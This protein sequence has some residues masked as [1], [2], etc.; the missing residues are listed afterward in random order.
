M[1]SGNFE[2]GSCWSWLSGETARLWNRASTASHSFF[3]P[4]SVAAVAWAMNRSP[5]RA[6]PAP[7]ESF[8]ATS[9]FFLLPG[10][11]ARE[12][13]PK[14]RRCRST[15]QSSSTRPSSE[16]TRGSCEAAA[17]RTVGDD[18][19]ALRVGRRT[20]SCENSLTFNTDLLSESRKV[21]EL[22]VDRLRDQAAAVLVGVDSLTPGLLAGA[23]L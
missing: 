2:R 14:R 6:N 13:G 3:W 1:H 20:S 21:L 11:G 22:G 17:I 12:E 15:A 10:A 8:L 18:G 16:S 4:S 23:R 9:A 7:V 5:S 19:P